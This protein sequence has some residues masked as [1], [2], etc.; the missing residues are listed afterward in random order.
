MRMSQLRQRFN[1]GEEISEDQEVH[2][3]RSY[4]R[5]SIAA[6]AFHESAAWYGPLDVAYVQGSPPACCR[7]LEKFGVVR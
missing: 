2:H 6:W 1:P 5:P 3:A 4:F 7:E